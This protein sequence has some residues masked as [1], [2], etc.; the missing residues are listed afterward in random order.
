MNLFFSS[1]LCVISEDGPDKVE[2]EVRTRTK[3]CCK[4]GWLRFQNRLGKH[5]RYTPRLP[6][7]FCMGEH[8]RLRVR[9]LIELNIAVIVHIAVVDMEASFTEILS[10]KDRHSKAFPS[11]LRKGRISVPSER[12]KIVHLRS[13]VAEVN[14]ARPNT[15]CSASSPIMFLVSQINFLKQPF[16][17]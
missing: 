13:R 6:L 3:E 12:L 5:S 7:N 15:S 4:I 17:A 2:T 1:L 16:C 8:I 9:I 14:S 11:K 10:S